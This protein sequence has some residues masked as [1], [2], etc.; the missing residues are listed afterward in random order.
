MLSPPFWGAKIFLEFF[1]KAI[2]KNPPIVYNILREFCKRPLT[3]SYTEM[4]S[5]G[6]RGAPAKGVGR[7]N[8]RESSNLSISAKKKDTDR[9]PF[10]LAWK[11]S[12]LDSL[13]V[14]DI[15][16]NEKLGS[17]LPRAE[18]GGSNLSIS[19]KKEVT[20]VYQKLLLFYPSRRLGME[21][22]RPA[23]CMESRRSRA[24]HCAKRV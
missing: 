2:D 21:S 14:V 3:L 13:Q 8:R 9:C 22:T 6:R 18:R 7:V 11:G 16:G 5:R 10:L 17:N 4:Y 12:R 15:Y 19:A 23:R 1:E 20:F 24:W